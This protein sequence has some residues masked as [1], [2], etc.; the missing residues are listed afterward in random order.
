[1][2]PSEETIFL[3]ALSYSGKEERE[4]FL[5]GACQGQSEL[6]TNVRAL[7]DG[8][9]RGEFLEHTLPTVADMRL[10]AMGHAAEKMI[11]PYHIRELIGRGG[12]GSVYMCKRR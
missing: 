8:Y 9:A 12:M 2:S 10:R 6:L 3:E 1:M 7:L 5:L 11:G 4:A